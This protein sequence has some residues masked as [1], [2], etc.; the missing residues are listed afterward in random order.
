MYRSDIQYHLSNVILPPKCG[1][2]SRLL[3]QA[4][5]W[6]ASRVKHYDILDLAEIDEEEIFLIGNFQWEVICW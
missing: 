5:I 2:L 1:L 6:T 4:Q 3:P